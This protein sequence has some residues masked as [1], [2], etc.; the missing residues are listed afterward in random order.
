MLDVLIVGAGPT[1]LFLALWLH[2][3]AVRVRVIDKAPGPGTASR[4]LAVHARTLEFYAML[5]LAEEAIAQGRKCEVLNYWAIGRHGARVPVGDIGKGL[6]P[7]PFVLILPQDEHERLLVARLQALQIPVEYR[8]ELIG[9]DQRPGGVTAE[10]KA[11]GGN[12]ESV[13]ARFLCGCDGAHSTVRHQLGVE[14]GGGSYSDLFYVADVAAT[15]PPV[16]GELHVFM[17]RQRFN[18]VFPMKGD[19][20]VRLVG[21]VPK[22]LRNKPD[23]RFE[24]CAPSIARETR[25]RISSV[26]WFSTYHVSHRVAESFRQG[27]VFLLGDAGHIHSPA[28]GQ[29]MNTGIGDAVNLAW[30]L[31]GVVNGHTNPAL[32]DSY[33]D[34]RIGFARQLVASTDRAFAMAVSRGFFAQFVRLRLMPF[35]LPRLFG[36]ERI[37]T[38]IFRTISQIAITYRGIPPNAGRA[39]D[40]LGG[41]RLP[42]VPGENGLNNFAP[43]KGI[44]WQAHVYGTAGPEL[45][46]FCKEKTLFLH[47]REWTQACHSAGLRQDALYLVRPDGHVGYASPIQNVAALRRYWDSVHARM[48]ADSRIS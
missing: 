38:R 1:G 28:G 17:N 36:L 19:G 16:N 43:L 22:R 42:W 21:L 41:D 46:N 8:T 45:A 20:H 30:K 37:R 34:E 35:L 18:A 14:F 26:N 13:E 25:T 48:M 4:A 6:S 5:G 9:F 15:G 29:G 47:E 40:I 12:I 39:D 3:Q 33:E 11:P 24:D 44:G 31:V 7:Y 10:V 27:R 32:L 23:L 2:R